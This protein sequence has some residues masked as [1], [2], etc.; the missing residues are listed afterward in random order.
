[1]AASVFSISRTAKHLQ[2]RAVLGACRFDP[3]RLPA[4]FLTI[5]S[6]DQS[7]RDAALSVQGFAAVPIEPRVF[8]IAPELRRSSYYLIP[9]AILLSGVAW[10]VESTVK[11]Y[12]GNHVVSVV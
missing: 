3:P 9:G 8:Q 5:G 12:E 4:R 1:M 6:T 10:W 2:L 7:S 11:I